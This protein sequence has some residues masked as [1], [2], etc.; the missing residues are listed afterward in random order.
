MVLLKGLDSVSYGFYLARTVL[1]IKHAVNFGLIYASVGFI[2]AFVVG[3][4]I[5]KWALRKKFNENNEVSLS[6][7]FDYWFSPL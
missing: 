6:Q 4:P 2:I 5:A 7:E 1:R 3:I